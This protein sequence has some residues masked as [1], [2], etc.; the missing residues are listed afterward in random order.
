MH[1]DNN[2]VLVYA[3]ENVW[4]KRVAFTW[5][6]VNPIVALCEMESGVMLNGNT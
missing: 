1:G 4:I 6:I 5:E 3:V 2:G